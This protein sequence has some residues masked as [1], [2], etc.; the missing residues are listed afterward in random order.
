LSCYV[1]ITFQGCCYR[2]CP[3]SS[4]WFSLVYSCQNRFL[5]PP[6]ELFW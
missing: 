6:I 1:Y 5:R 3:A 2:K 4:A